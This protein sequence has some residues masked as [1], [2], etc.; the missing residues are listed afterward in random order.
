MN[1][2]TNQ[3]AKLQRVADSAPNL[4][5]LSLVSSALA[6]VAVSQAEKLKLSL[7]SVRTNNDAALK[8]IQNL[9]STLASIR[10]MVEAASSIASLKELLPPVPPQEEELPI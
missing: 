4:F 3:A 7:V 10:T 1:T 8:D 6:D 9:Q 2:I 5:R